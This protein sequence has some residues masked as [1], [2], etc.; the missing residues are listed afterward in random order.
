MITKDEL[1][2]W[3]SVCE[4]ATEKMP[5]SP[6][7]LT[8]ES[9]FIAIARSALPRAI[10]RVQELERDLQAE[11]LQL[12]TALGEAVELEAKNER[13]RDH[14]RVSEEQNEALGDANNLAVQLAAALKA[15]DEACDIAANG[16]ADSQRIAALRSIGKGGDRE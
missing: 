3:L 16:W 5:Y 11:R 12:I 13:L 1:S 14:L 6:S 2:H 9:T 7:S 10:A 15:K 8:D 4:A